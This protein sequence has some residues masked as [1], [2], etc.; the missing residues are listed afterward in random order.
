M[1]PAGYLINTPLPIGERGTAYTYVLAGNGVFLE[2][3]N[4][5]VRTRI[6]LAEASV[7]GLAPLGPYLELKHSLVPGYLMDL[8]VSACCARPDQE[9]YAAI[10][11]DGQEYRVVF[12]VQ[13]GGGGHVSYEVVPNTVVGVH[14]HGGMGAFFSSTDDADDQGFLV[15]VVLGEVGRLVPMARARLCVYG[16]FAPAEL[17]EVFSGPVSVLEDVMKDGMDGLPPG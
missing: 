15:S 4:P 6:L 14:S 5:L 8:V 7:R 16:Y 1:K 17:E 13:D 3:E 9:V 11:W 2:A 12:P 10:A